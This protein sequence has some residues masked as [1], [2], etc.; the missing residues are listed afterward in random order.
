MTQKL[1]G[2]RVAILVADGFEQVEMTKPREALVQA[3]AEVTIVSPADGEV[4]GMN[5]A[6]KGDTFPVD[7]ALA[8]AH[9]DQFDALM[10]PGGLMNPDEL[11][12]TPKA[13]EFVKHFFDAKKP[14]AAICHG[15]WVL[16]DAGVVRGRTLT[17]WPAIQTDVKNAGGKWVD[18][19]VVVDMGLVTS[20]KPD[21]I[22][23]FNKKMIEEFAEGSHANRGR[24]RERDSQVHSHSI[25]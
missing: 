22:P 25:H 4:Q 17:S 3:G 18:Q 23:A 14:V 11:R 7:L 2:K 20:R 12:S 19:E 6:D 13:L 1:Q 16:I 5:H 10:I 15:P 24:G 9:P 8:V 21:D